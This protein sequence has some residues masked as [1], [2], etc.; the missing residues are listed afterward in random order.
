MIAISID[1]KACVNCSL[2]VET[3]PTKVFAFDQA[4]E[5]P[6]VD[7]PKECFGCLS[8]SEICPAGAIIHEGAMRTETF[9][10]D[11]YALNLARKLATEEAIHYQ[12]IDTVAARD[13]AMSDLSLRL[14][15]VGAVLKEIVGG[16][17][18]SVGLM[19]GRSL[20][21][22]LPRYRPPRN[23]DEALALAKL[24][25]APAWEL[26][27]KKTDDQSLQITVGKCFVRELCIKE[28]MT[29]GGELCILFFHY[30]SGYLSKM[31]KNQLKLAEANRGQ[32]GCCYQVKITR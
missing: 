15:S 4:T 18:A 14:L 23:L 21:S 30:L 5:L 1:D 10:H 28:N 11:P 27:F 17:L 8:C 6:T 3:C 24:E 22:Q 12:T 13:A 16:G 20:A 26:D 19:A 29:L 25:F 32:D 9:Y 7:H 31:A 2:C